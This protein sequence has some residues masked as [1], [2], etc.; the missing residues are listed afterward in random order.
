MSDKLTRPL[1][2]PLTRDPFRPG[3]R[4]D[5]TPVKPI[6]TVTGVGGNVRTYYSAYG[7]GSIGFS[8]SGAV[9]GEYA[10]ISSAGVTAVLNTGP[11][12]LDGSVSL[13][14]GVVYLTYNFT[15]TPT[16]ITLNGDIDFGTFVVRFTD[17]V[18]DPLRPVYV[19]SNF[20]D[21]MQDDTSGAFYFSIESGGLPTATGGNLDSLFVIGIEGS[22]TTGFSEAS[23]S[24]GL[25]QL[26]FNFGDGDPPS[27]A[28]LNGPIE[29]A[30]FTTRFENFSF[31][32]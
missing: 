9:E 13:A 3:V 7:F 23:T 11:T 29:F 24:S 18:V 19:I 6:Y 31:S 15:G 2:R 22:T 1:T 28:T 26:A 20:S 5:T 17:V 27:G 4:N 32:F 21:H 12:S 16:S 10:D 25:L 30:D 14:G 8:I